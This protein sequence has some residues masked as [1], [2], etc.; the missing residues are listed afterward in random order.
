MKKYLGLFCVL[1][2]FTSLVLIGGCPFDSSDSTSSDPAD[3]TTTTGSTDTT[4]TTDTTDTTGTSAFTYPEATIDHMGFDFSAGA[5]SSDSDTYDGGT[6]GWQP[7]GGDNPSYP[8]YGDYLWWRNT[9]LDTVNQ[10]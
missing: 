7:G 3:T 6:I 1:L 8:S 9:H 4:G 2:M 5:S 10:V